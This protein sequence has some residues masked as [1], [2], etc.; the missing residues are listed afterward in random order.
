MTLDDY[1]YSEA[2]AQQ[3]A[4]RAVDLVRWWAKGYGIDNKRSEERMCE[5]I[6]TMLAL[7][8]GLKEGAR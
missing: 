3:M 2:A 5:E 1:D 7:R 6:A 4:Q 8:L